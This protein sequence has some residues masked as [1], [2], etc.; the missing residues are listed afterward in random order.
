MHEQSIYREG[1]ILYK[2]VPIIK[3]ENN[4]TAIINTVAFDALN[5]ENRRHYVNK[6]WNEIETLSESKIMLELIGTE[7]LDYSECCKKTS[8]FILYFG[9]LYSP[10][11]CGD[12]FEPIPIYSIPE[13][14]D[15]GKGYDNIFF[16]RQNYNSCYQLWFD[17]TVNEDF[18]LKQLSDFTSEISIQGF[19]VC[20]SIEKT[21]N[22]KVYYFLMEFENNI[23]KCPSCNNDFEVLELDKEINKICHNCKIV[24]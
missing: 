6:Y 23:K 9:S 11:R 16:W 22:K 1:Q 5:Y 8:F 12:C 3:S 4:F 24:M 10:I 21:T 2:N 20:K 19:E 15:D 14:N 13:T 7:Y 17:G 18:H